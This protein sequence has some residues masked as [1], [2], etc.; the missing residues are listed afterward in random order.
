METQMLFSSVTSSS[1]MC[2]ERLVPFVIRVFTVL[3]LRLLAIRELRT[4]SCSRRYTGVFCSRKYT[5]VFCSRRYVQVYSVAGGIQVYSV[6]I[7]NTCCFLLHLQLSET[8]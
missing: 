3:A 7:Y 1:V 6:T 5:G 8:I 2:L 4:L